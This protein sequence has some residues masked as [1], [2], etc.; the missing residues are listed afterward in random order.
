MIRFWLDFDSGVTEVTRVTGVIKCTSGS[1]HAF[2]RSEIAGGG[3]AAEIAGGG[4]AALL[5]RTA[6][7]LPGRASPSHD[8]PQSPSREAPS[9]ASLA[10]R[11]AS[12]RIPGIS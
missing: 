12:P 2:F 1:F 3:A 7:A 8:R 5:A 4:A 11:Y 6:D 10:S 9:H